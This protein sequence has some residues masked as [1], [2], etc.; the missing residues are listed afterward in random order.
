MR[1]DRH[2]TTQHLSRRRPQAAG[3]HLCSGERTQPRFQLAECTVGRSDPPS[4]NQP[5]PR[6]RF[7]DAPCP[8]HQLILLARTPDH[9]HPAL[10]VPN[11]TGPMLSGTSASNVLAK[12]CP[13]GSSPPRHAFLRRARRS[14]TP[15][16]SL[17]SKLCLS[18]T[19]GECRLAYRDHGGPPSRHSNHTAAP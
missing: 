5:L 10:R 8:A 16:H 17:R 3:Y 18:R 15:P 1:S 13:V 9:H 11:T 4:L 2:W 12:I 19:R 14:L 6:T 7:P